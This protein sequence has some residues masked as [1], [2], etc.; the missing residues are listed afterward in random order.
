MTMHTINGTLDATP[1]FDFAQSLRFLGG[2]MPSKDG[3]VIGENSLTRA[4]RLNAQTVAFQVHSMGS[5]ET[6]HLEYTLFS[7][8]TITPAVQAALEDRIT[9]F[10]SLRDDLLPFYALAQGDSDFEPVV[11]KL[12]GYHQVKFLTPFENACWAILSSRNTFSAARTLK[13]RISD[14][15]GDAILLDGVSV[16][17]FPSAED[18]LPA[19]PAD[20]VALI[21]N[22]QR[23][24]YV[25][26]AARAFASV[27][28][29]WLRT[30]DYD[31]VYEW[32]RSIKGVGEWTASF[33]M[34]RSLGRMER[35]ISP[36][37]R[38][39]EST[40]EAYGREI[41]KAALLELA[42]RYGAHK[43]Y[44]SHYLRAAG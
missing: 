29:A 38:L 2:F 9:H 30:G 35:L 13:N 23:G 33:I 5:I 28:E 7:E 44:W 40:S 17:A 43:A 14:S 6:P 21:R 20:L 25:W 19:S 11:E 10:L 3:Q 42:E 18:V 26:H 8:E 1:P 32:L 15:Y 34:I 41:D 16:A 36:E 37:K 4:V 22:E 31:E 24:E 12:Y 27:D 39:L